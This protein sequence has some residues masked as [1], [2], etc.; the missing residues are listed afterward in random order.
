MLI[1]KLIYCYITALHKTLKVIHDYK[2]IKCPH[3]LTVTTTGCLPRAW[4][5]RAW[6]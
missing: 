4:E 6:A 2:D 3:F 5:W 1:Y